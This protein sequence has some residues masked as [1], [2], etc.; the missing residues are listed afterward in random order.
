VLLALSNS[1]SKATA[2]MNKLVNANAT[3]EKETRQEDK[4]SRDRKSYPV[5]SVYQE[6]FRIHAYSAEST[7]LIAQN[8]GHR[9]DPSPYFYSGDW[10]KVNKYEKG[11]GDQILGPRFCRLQE[12][13]RWRCP[14]MVKF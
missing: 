1:D 9:R 6:L 11:E 13:R 14:T 2:E 12:F 8:S 10:K 7:H 4:G 5:S 3:V